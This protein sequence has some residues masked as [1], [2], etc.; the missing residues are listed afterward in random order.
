MRSVERFTNK[1]IKI[2]F[3][4]TTNYDHNFLPLLYIP[5][6]LGNAEQFVEEMEYLYPR[7]C[8]S[9]SLRGRG[10]SDAPLTGYTFEEHIMDISSVMNESNISACCLMAYSM[11]VPYAIKYAAMNPSKIKGLIV[12][13]YPAKYP[14]IQETWIE[15]VEELVEEGRK[16]VV[17]EIQKDSKEIVLW[18]ELK[19]ISCP[20]L[21][22]KGGTE[23]AVLNKYKAEKYKNNLKNVE[24]VEFSESGHELWSPD[25]NKFMRTIAN[26][27]KK[28][29]H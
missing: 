24:L 12:C 13:D 18:E 20:V 10:K 11:G 4:E 14:L 28:L 21:V 26:F 6:A 5:G 22:M 8:L 1:G 23:K 29:D 25:Y 19:E 17:R 27:L 7:H 16:H 9:I 15:A 3:I 2:H